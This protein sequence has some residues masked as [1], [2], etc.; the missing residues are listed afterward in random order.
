MDKIAFIL[1]LFRAPGLESRDL[2][3]KVTNVKKKAKPGI[4]EYSCPEIYFSVWYWL[5]SRQPELNNQ[6][7]KEYVQFLL[8]VYNQ[9]P[10]KNNVLPEL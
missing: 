7:G 8:E 10:L 4:S 6:I 5:K 1:G 3:M 9:A 2:P